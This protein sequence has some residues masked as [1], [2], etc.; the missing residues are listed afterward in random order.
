MPM[1]FPPNRS[2]AGADDG[3]PDD[4]VVEEDP[5]ADPP[6]RQRAAKVTP[7]CPRCA[8]EGFTSTPDTISTRNLLLVHEATYV[9]GRAP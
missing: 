1:Q 7:R 4:G 5:H 9:L 8:G 6:G 3:A 2:R